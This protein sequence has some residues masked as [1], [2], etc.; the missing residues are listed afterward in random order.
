MP[1]SDAADVRCPS[2]AWSH[3]SCCLLHGRLQEDCAEK[4]VYIRRLEA[5]LEELQG[6]SEAAGKYQTAKQKVRGSC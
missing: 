2:T 1:A 3:L 4:Q 5:K 6:A